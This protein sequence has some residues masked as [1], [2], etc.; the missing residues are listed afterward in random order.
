MNVQPP[1]ILAL[2]FKYQAGEGQVKYFA[3]ATAIRDHVAQGIPAL[4]DLF[5]VTP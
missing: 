5:V 4:A 2:Q 3:E 1:K